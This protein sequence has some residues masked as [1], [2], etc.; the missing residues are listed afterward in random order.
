M[1][2]MAGSPRCYRVRRY[3]IASTFRLIAIPDRRQPVA[4]GRANQPAIYLLHAD[5][6]ASVRRQVAIELG[7]CH[8]H[9]PAGVV[10]GVS[11]GKRD[12]TFGGFLC[13]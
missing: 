1:L 10:V 9:A 7:H 5:A 3:G 4:M 13:T 11:S 8:R 12:R 2:V 6:D